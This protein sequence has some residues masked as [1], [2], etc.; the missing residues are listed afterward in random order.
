MN[1][2]KSSKKY[3][4]E[5]YLTVDFINDILKILQVKAEVMAKIFPKRVEKYSNRELSILWGH[6]KDYINSYVYRIRSAKQPD[7]RFKDKTLSLLKKQV[8]KKLNVKALGILRLITLYKNSN[9]TTLDFINKLK[10]E[11][12]RISGDIEVSL[13]ELSQLFGKS[14]NY[15]VTVKRSVEDIH[16]NWFKN[17]F[18]FSKEILNNLKENLE[19]DKYSF[20]DVFYVIREFERCNPNIPDYSHQQY[21]ISNVGAFDNIFNIKSS[22]WFGFLCADGY[23]GRLENKNSH[24]ICF[25]LA[26]KDEASVY[27]FAEFV[28]FDEEN[29]RERT[30]IFIDESGCIKRYKMVSIEFQAKPMADRLRELGIFGSKSDIKSIPKYVQQVIKLAKR[31][32]D[33]RNYNWSDTFYGK[34]A[35]AWLL[36]FYDGDGNLRRYSV[37]IFSSVKSL[38]E[39]IKDLFESPNDINMEKKPNSIDFIINRYSRTKGFYSLTLGPEVFK[40]MLLSYSGS[41]KRKRG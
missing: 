3:H 39:N 4:R 5:L 19:I 25:E 2:L 18:K 29:V 20:K 15:M 12:G 23:V 6:Q 24:R 40:R 22:Y 13:V 41:M 10:R 36:G 30:R 9:M 8:I 14:L 37:R 11:L 26:K 32:A 31:E 38:L 17:D 21:T 35:H 16:I 33:G 1:S 7:F 27:K 28:G 34:V